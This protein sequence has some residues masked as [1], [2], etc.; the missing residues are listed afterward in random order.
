MH[1]L[2]ELSDFYKICKSIVKNYPPQYADVN[3]PEM[4]ALRPNTFAVVRS[5][6]D[7]DADNVAK[8]PQFIDSPYFYSRNWA[9]SEYR[10]GQFKLEYP[11]VGFAEDTTTLRVGRSDSA[12]LNFFVIDQIPKG[13]NFY[14]DTYSEQREI[15]D[16]A[17]DIRSHFIKMI[18]VLQNFAYCKSL[19]NSF[20]DGWYDTA[21][22]DRQ[23]I[24]YQVITGL[25]SLVNF[26]EVT[27]EIFPAIV[28]NCLIGLTNINVKIDS[29]IVAPVINY[30]SDDFI[31]FTDDN[32]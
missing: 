12:K 29:C 30:D 28:D 4:V 11:V 14:E 3:E 9:N 10:S 2:T 21:W 1:G 19:S 13:G 25:D 32:C 23:N 15:E 8:R 7:F 26:N 27:V 31:K 24:D 22:L 18:V 16:V 17:R 5:L 20:E 6:K